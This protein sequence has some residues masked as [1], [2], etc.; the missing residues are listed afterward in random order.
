MSHRRWNLQSPDHQLHRDTSE[1]SILRLPPPVQVMRQE[2]STLLKEGLL[3]QKFLM[4][5]FDQ[6]CLLIGLCYLCL[7][8]RLSSSWSS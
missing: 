4:L 1:L 8:T 5:H 2:L 6:K 3:S 7:K